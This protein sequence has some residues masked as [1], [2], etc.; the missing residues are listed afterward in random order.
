MR[1]RVRRVHFVGIGGAGMSGLAE[2]LHASGYRVSGSDRADASSTRRLAARGIEVGIGHDAAAVEGADVVVFSAAVP[3][4]NVELRAAERARIPVI[5]RAEMLAELMR[6][7]HGVAIS[8]SHG[9]TTTTSLVGE[10][11][12]AGGLDPTT[13]AGGRVQNLGA[14]SRLGAGDILVAEADESDG[15]FLKLAPTLVVVTNVDREHLDHYREFDNLL[16][17]FADFANRVP[18]YG[19]AIACIDDPSVQ[20]LLPRLSRR[21]RTYGLSPQADVGAGEVA[22]DGLGMRF[23]ARSGTRELGEVRLSMPGEHNVANALAALAVGEE[24]GVPFDRAR[25]ALERFAGVAR[26]F[27]LCG[28]RAGVRVVDDYAHH[29]TEIRATLRA[30][31]RAFDGRLAVVFQPHR[32]T[33]T[34][35]LFDELSR[36]FHEADRVW[37]T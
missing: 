31:R 1:H 30:A 2:I 15:S 8:G 9:K 14:N 20:A 12:G 4:T 5:S 22:A 35:D 33:R 21:V 18:F 37:I 23:V 27:E 32:Y 34:R 24:L 19:A 10:V 26:R 3:A 11:L 16:Q 13:I 29:P 36:A 28:E 25:E 7:K 17:A 6:L